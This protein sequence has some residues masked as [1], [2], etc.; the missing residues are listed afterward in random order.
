MKVS[1]CSLRKILNP[2]ILEAHNYQVDPYIGCEHFCFYCYSLN[3]A[4]TDWKKEIL[5]HE[6]ITGQLSLEMN[7]LEPQSIYMGMNSDPYQPSER[8]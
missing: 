8:A 3:K 1:K 4:E 6:D 5:I 7:S 2:C